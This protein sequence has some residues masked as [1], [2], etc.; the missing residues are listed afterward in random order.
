MELG[1]IMSETPTPGTHSS[2]PVLHEKPPSD[3]FQRAFSVH[4]TLCQVICE[5]CGRT[6][7]VGR[8]IASG[9]YETGELTELEA[10]AKRLPEWFLEEMEFD[11]IDTAY[12]G[13]LQIVTHCKCHYLRTWEEFIYRQRH[14]VAKYLRILTE[15]AQ[16]HAAREESGLKVPDDSTLDSVEKL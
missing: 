9:D 1:G 3:L 5:P 10:N 2:P 12:I 11:S 13:E 16:Q 6:H 4:S 7:Y 15:Q 14:S 8:G